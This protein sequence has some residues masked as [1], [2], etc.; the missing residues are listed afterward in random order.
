MRIN[1]LDD[2]LAI[3]RRLK[4][5][6]ERPYNGFPYHLAYP[7]TP[8][9]RNFKRANPQLEPTVCGITGFSDPADP[10]G[11]GYIFTH[12]ENYEEHQCLEWL[13][14]CKLAHRL[15]HDRFINPKAWFRFVA[16]HYVHGAW[17]T[18]LTTSPVKMFVR[19]APSGGIM[20]PFW[21]IYPKGLPAHGEFWPEYATEAGISRDLFL[22]DDIRET[23]KF[24]WNFPGESEGNSPAS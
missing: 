4:S 14:C 1:T 23:I 24:F 10:R 22:A 21:S 2:Y 6:K 16:E 17:W 11:R 13:P 20:R 5:D 15:L 9:Q 3:G 18:M 19:P 8:I 7:A 12:L